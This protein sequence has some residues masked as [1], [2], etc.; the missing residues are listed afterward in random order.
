MATTTID[1]SG[2]TTGRGP[3][4]VVRGARLIYTIGAGIF[5]AAVVLQVFFAGLAV[6]ANPNY[7]G[8]HRAFGSLI[9]F[10]PL[11]LLLIG[12]VARLPWRLIGLTVVLVLLFMLQYIFLYAPLG[13][14]VMELRALHA[15]NAF[16][17]AGTAAQLARGAAGLSRRSD[18][19]Q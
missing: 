3:S 1:T 5:A 2:A 6:L 13:I 17:L 12:L 4:A 19:S 16:A 7:W 10:L 11:A 18:P 14:G 15:V 8:L 9:G